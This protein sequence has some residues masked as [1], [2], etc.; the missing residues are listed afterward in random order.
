[1]MALGI[2]TGIAILA[3]MIYTALSKKS[4]S[5]V[6]IASL[7]ALAVMIITL[8]ICVILIFSTDT[9]F[10]DE[11]IVHVIPPPHHAEP[12][13][14]VTNVFLLLFFILLL[15]GLLAAVTV[16]S[17]KEHRKNLSMVKEKEA[18]KKAKAHDLFLDDDF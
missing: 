16:T 9:A 10:V 11:S 18:E 13:R 15:A 5:R 4:S 17:L 14:D 12:A 2:I 3:G 1:M 6:R 7:I 8:I